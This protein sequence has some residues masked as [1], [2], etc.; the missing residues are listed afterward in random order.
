LSKFKRLRVSADG[1]VREIE[2]TVQSA[3]GWKWYESLS[4]FE[5]LAR[6]FLTANFVREGLKKSCFFEIDRLY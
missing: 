5:K 4:S 1:Q 3:A 2:N 6:L